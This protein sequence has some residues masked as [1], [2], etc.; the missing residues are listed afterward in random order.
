M[1]AEKEKEVAPIVFVP[2]GEGLVDTLAYKIVPEP[3]CVGEL[4]EQSGDTMTSIELRLRTADGN[5]R[6]NW[7]ALA[8]AGSVHEKL[9]AW[10]KGGSG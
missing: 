4:F 3:E 6:A 8:G 2:T 9:K 5:A 10:A 7:A 1:H